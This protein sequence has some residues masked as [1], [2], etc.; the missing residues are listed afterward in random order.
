METARRFDVF[1][2]WDALDSRLNGAVTVG[3]RERFAAIE[4]WHVIGEPDE[5]RFRSYPA[6][7]FPVYPGEPH[8]TGGIYYEHGAS[9]VSFFRDTS[10]MV[11]L[12]GE[13]VR[14]EWGNNNFDAYFYPPFALPPGY[15]ERGELTSFFSVA[16]SR[17]GRA[18]EEYDRPVVEIYHGGVFSAADRGMVKIASGLHAGASIYLDGIRFLAAPVSR[19]RYITDDARPPFGY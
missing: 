10:G 5:P 12:R 14:P 9:P 18:T 7:A 11:H 17:P 8:P 16:G 13:L 3:A 6:S 1:R 15:R 4:D 19:E 2:F